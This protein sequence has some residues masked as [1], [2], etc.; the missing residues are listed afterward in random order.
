MDTGELNT[1]DLGSAE[2]TPETGAA[3]PANETELE[4]EDVGSQ[5]P[6]EESAASENQGQD[7]PGSCRVA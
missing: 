5:N 2:P 6:D 7:D 3:E 1:L 4:V